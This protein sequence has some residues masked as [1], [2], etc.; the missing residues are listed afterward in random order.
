M[1]LLEH[2]R[3]LARYAGLD[4]AEVVLEFGY[5][6]EAAAT[7]PID[8]A[9]ALVQLLRGWPASVE[10]WCVANE[11][12]GASEP[13]MA[14]AEYGALLIDHLQRCDFHQPSSMPLALSCTAGLRLG[15]LEECWTCRLRILPDDLLRSYAG[16]FGYVVEDLGPRRVYV[17]G[18]RILKAQFGWPRMAP[19]LQ[20][21]L[22]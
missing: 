11:V 8:L 7:E 20:G 16:H 9:P 10:L 4:D 19:M 21:W 18:S 13:S 5:L 12:L 6:L 15:A 3:Y 14:A 2:F 1:A 22:T 17:D